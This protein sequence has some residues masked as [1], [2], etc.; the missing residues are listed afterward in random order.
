[1]SYL[2]AKIV[3]DIAQTPSEHIMEVLAFGYKVLRE[4]QDE[5]NFLPEPRL[6]RTCLAVLV[7]CRM[8]RI[9]DVL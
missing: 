6:R 8:V 9:S 5:E 7:L 4:D 3:Q 1:M 2:C